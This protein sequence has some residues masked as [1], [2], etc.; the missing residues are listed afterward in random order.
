MGYRQMVAS[1]ADK[2]VS[3]EN[4]KNGLVLIVS[5]NGAISNV[6]EA[7]ESISKD[8]TE[9]TLSIDDIW[10]AFVTQ[11]IRNSL[12]RTL[13]NRKYHSEEIE[14]PDDSL[15]SEFIYVAQGPDRVLLIARDLS[16]QKLALSRVQELAYT[17]EATGLPNREYLFR[18]LQKISDIQSLKEGRAA[19]ICIHVGQID[20]QGYTLNSAQQDEMLRELASRLTKH[21]RGSNELEEENYE[22]SSVAART[23]FRQFGVILPAIESGADAEAVVERLVAD[24]QQPVAAGTRT[25]CV[26]AAGGVAL[27][28]QDGTDP[29]ALFENAKAAMEDA[30]NQ[31]SS[32]KFHSGTVRLRTLQR[33]DLEI[34]LKSALE[35]EEYALNFLP[36][37]DAQTRQPRTIEALLRWPDTIL[38]LQST[39]KI[40]RV[41]ERTGQIVAIGEWVLRHACEQLQLWRDAGHTNIRVAVNLSAQELVTDG[42]DGKIAKI[43][44]ETNTNPADL[45]IELKE[46]MLTREALK[47]FATCKALKS[48]GVRLV[49][50]D[51]GVGACS[52]AT[53]SQ[54]PVDAIK[55]DNTFVAHLESNERDRAACSAATAISE[56]LGID[57]IAEGVE[58][59]E[60]ARVLQEQGCRYL[61]GFLFCRPKTNTEILDYL[62]TAGREGSGREGIQ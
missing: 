29:A 7:P 47:D 3:V 42:I 23:D 37:V 48:L 46:Q 16:E 54:S 2:T 20:D 11:K 58:T 21:L 15:T 34:E 43:L 62:S 35:R 32:F 9:N 27:F 61:Q 40:V 39:R 28:P 1:T 56:R 4:A 14:N 25:I 45:D 44:D 36:I 31:G 30:R 55:I 50:D 51:Y 18:Q 5:Q 6:L 17:D 19:M 53:L 38:G 60:Q 10:P 49:V 41:A 8:A 57:V 12:K 59:E 13:R 26:R 33:Q 52:L 22:R 24:L